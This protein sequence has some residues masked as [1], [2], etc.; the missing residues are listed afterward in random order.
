MRYPFVPPEVIYR[1]YYVPYS[2]VVAVSPRPADVV[3]VEAVTFEEL[4]L[5]ARVDV[6]RR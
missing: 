4:V 6:L 5:Q 3:A 1:P 2:D